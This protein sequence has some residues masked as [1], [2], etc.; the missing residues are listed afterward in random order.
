MGRPEKDLSP[1]GALGRLAQHLRLLR[2]QS[3]LTYRDMAAR[4][5]LH[6]STLS[7]AAG[8]STLPQ[9]NT[10]MAYTWACGAETATS[11]RLWERAA[12][13]TLRRRAVVR[14]RLRRPY[15]PEQVA[16]VNGLAN[17]LRYLRLRAGQPSL[18]TLEAITRSNGTRLPRSTASDLLR[19]NTHNPSLSAV[20]A[21]A[22][23]CGQTDTELRR[24]REAWI[25]AMTRTHN[26][27][28]GGPGESHP[29]AIRPAVAARLPPPAA[30][31]R[32]AAAPRRARADAGADPG[33]R[34]TP[35]GPRPA[36]APQPRPHA[37]E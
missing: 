9:W 15:Y 23:A 5:H 27:W 28:S 19:G 25:R 32:P 2:Q 16:T 6:A 36:Q 4:T 7:R 34:R 14:R 26:A 33:R 11:R 3:S 37:S 31:P 13:E 35:A 21:L 17:A 8:G 12:T 24:W 22:Q 20:L 18:Q 1:A 29:R 10:V 30:P